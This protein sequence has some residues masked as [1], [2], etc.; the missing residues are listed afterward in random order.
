MK[1]IAALI[2]AVYAVF[3]F[4]AC[5]Y[6]EEQVTLESG[7]T[8]DITL[9]PPEGIVIDGSTHNI[10]IREKFDEEKVISSLEVTEYTYKNEF[11]NYA[12][13]AVRN[14][15]DFTI[16]ISADAKFYDETGALVGAKSAGETTVGK[17][18]EVLLCF[19]P[20]EDFAKMEYEISADEDKWY[21]SAVSALSYE[22]V[23][24]KDKEIVSVKNN[25]SEAV[26]F[27]ECEVLFFNG[28]KI[29]GYS[30]EYFTDDDFEIKPGKTITKE[31]NCYDE[32]DSVK[33]FFTGRR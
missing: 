5:F 1:K 6:S 25:G 32:Y 3:A 12:F 21:E 18:Q 8:Q 27:S 31:L 33:F 28:D 16:N 11:W 17:G 26:E 7:K 29:V 15:S 24:A 13:I 10:V 2:L 14:N 9:P 4:T 23:K 22:S 19:M 30:S 20:D